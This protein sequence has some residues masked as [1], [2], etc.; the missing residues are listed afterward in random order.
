MNGLARTGGALVAAA[1]AVATGLSFTRSPGHAPGQVLVAD[2][3]VHPFPG[4]GA[5]TI[6]QLQREAR[7]R[8]LD[9]IA[10]T[11]HNNQAGWTFATTVGAVDDSAVIV[12]PGQEVTAPD[13]HMAAIGIPRLVNWDQDARA[14]IA[15]VHALGGAVI[16]AHP[17]KDSWQPRNAE[18]LAVVDGVEIA[19]PERENG[20]EEARQLDE[21]FAA[22]MEANPRISAIG[23][24]DFHMGAPLG[25]FR[26]YV[27]ADERSAAG[28]IRAVR[29]G[30]TVAEDADG[31][32]YG[33][34]EL[35]ARVTPELRERRTAFAP[36]T[37]EK[38]CA[39]LALLGLALIC[40]APGRKRP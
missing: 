8:G 25:R 34:A 6:R 24:S 22:A 9:V 17:V 5:L 3:H 27:F 36:S 10:V 2:F 19:H 32:L 13:F 14:V 21:L 26:T 37:G 16:A 4:D 30:R 29:T 15:D 39:L 11:G 12:L 1:L 28:V 18:T 7:R 20:A 33:P 40:A 31:R 38:A 35:A 23:S